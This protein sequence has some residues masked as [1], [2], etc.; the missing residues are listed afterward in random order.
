MHKITKQVISTAL[1]LSIVGGVG[2]NLYSA[3]EE[4]NSTTVSK[5]T[6]SFNGD[7]KSSKG[8]TWYTSLASKNSDLQVVKK[9]G[10]SQTLKKL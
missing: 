6:V 8:F 3:A 1:A 4:S 10:R 5:V 7:S 2:G 9:Q